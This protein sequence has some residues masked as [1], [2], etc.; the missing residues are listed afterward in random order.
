MLTLNPRQTAA[1]LDCLVA[2][3]VAGFGVTRAD[4]DVFRALLFKF[5]NKRTGECW[6]SYKSIAVAAGVG[7]STVA[8][9][10]QRLRAAGWLRWQR[11]RRYHKVGRRRF[12]T[13]DS[14]DYEL[15]IPRRWRRVLSESRGRPGTTSI[16]TKA[17]AGHLMRPPPAKVQLVQKEAPAAPPARFGDNMLA[18]IEDEGLRRSLARLGAAV[19]A[20]EA[21][22]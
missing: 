6:P 22:G 5:R 19:A 21:V 4:A 17:A 15:R 14:N 1:V 16:L 10:I 13:Q 12:W 7:R 3:R 9:S 11:R 20:R 2:D 18:G 8:E